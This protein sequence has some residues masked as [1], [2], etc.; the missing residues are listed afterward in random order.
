MNYL[1]PYYKKYIKHQNVFPQAL[2]MTA[3]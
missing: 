1:G 3:Y 2:C